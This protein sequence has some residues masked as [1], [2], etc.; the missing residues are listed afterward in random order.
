MSNRGR[1]NIQVNNTSDREARYANLLDRMAKVIEALTPT[2]PPISVTTPVPVHQERS[3]YDRFTNE[4]IPEFLG[5]PDP[6]KAETWIQMRIKKTFVRNRSVA[7]Y[8]SKFT[9]LSRYASFMVEDEE[10]KVRRFFHGLRDDIRRHLSTLTLTTYG[11]VLAKAVIY[12][13]ELEK[14]AMSRQRT[15][16]QVS[17][18]SASE[19][20][21]KK[22]RPSRF[23]GE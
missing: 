20:P 9:E 12:E 2:T 19:G 11:E 15:F 14:A 5:E 7:E 6:L 10:M 17:K 13:K 4:R 18:A 22:A 16:S 23:S 21:S 3:V 8:D 1:R